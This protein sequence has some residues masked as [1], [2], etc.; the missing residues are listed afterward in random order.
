MCTSKPC[1]LNLCFKSVNRLEIYK[2]NKWKHSYIIV[3]NSKILH[4]CVCS[5]TRNFNEMNWFCYILLFINTYNHKKNQVNS[6]KFHLPYR[7]VSQE[8]QL[9]N[10]YSNI[11]CTLVLLPSTMRDINSKIFEDIVKGAN[12]VLTKYHRP[13]D[14]D[15]PMLFLYT[16]PTSKVYL[17]NLQYKYMTD[18]QLNNAHT[19][20]ALH[21]LW[22]TNTRL[23]QYH[24]NHHWKFNFD[25]PIIA[26]IE[27]RF[28]KNNTTNTKGNQIISFVFLTFVFDS[29]FGQRTDYRPQ[30]ISTFNAN[31]LMRLSGAQY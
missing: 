25:N 13:T 30:S 16:A 1:V 28:C 27:P 15:N 4:S 24:L 31:D 5:K 3:T 7:F 19:Y 10:W 2:E 29:G 23:P 9:N 18:R 6:L 12:L 14:R 11:C 21:S 17:R 8:Y 22:I 20:S 26:V